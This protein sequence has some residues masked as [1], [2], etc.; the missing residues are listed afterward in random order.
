MTDH[1]VP[2]DAAVQPE[3]PPRR[4]QEVAVE[5]GLDPDTILPHGHFIAKVPFGLLKEQEQM[6]Q[7]DGHLILMTAM[8]PTPQGEGKTTTTI[9]LGDALRRM[10]EKTAIC[11]R[12]PSLGPYFGI[13]GGGTGAGRAQVTPAEAINL[14][15]TGDMYSVTKANNLLAAMVDNHIHHGNGL[16]I[17][18]RRIVLR[19]VMD[20]NDRALREIFVGLGGVKNGVPRKDGFNITPASEVMAILCLAD[21]YADLGRRLGDMVVGF[22]YKGEPVRATAIEAVG[23]MQV[24]L[25]DAIHPNLVQT[26][27]GTPAF[28]HGGPFA[29]IAQGT[30]TAMAT[31]MALKL[32][33]YVVTEAGFAT[34]LGAEKFFDIKC[35][36]AG[37][38][39]SA[40]VIVAT[41]K[42][43]VWHGGF[44][45]KGGLGNLL[46]HILNIRR[47]GLEPVVA[48][49]RFPQD[50]PADLR[51]IQR[52]CAGQNVE[53]IV[54]THFSEG[55][56]GAHDLAVAVRRA[57]QRNRRRRFRFLYPLT[58]SLEAKIG[59]VARNLYGADGVD[60]DRSAETD[61][62]LLTRHGF[63]RL[64]I[65]VAKTAL[66]LS[67]KP[68]LRGRP[69][70]F[71]ITVQELRL[72]AGAGFVVVICGNIV[73]MP[74]LPRVPAAARI[75]VLPD[76]RAIGLS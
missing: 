57:I 61:L 37:L 56:A 43:V 3:Q 67:D 5:L 19:R 76:G 29:N 41:V 17:D 73:T 10:G 71:R 72:A 59:Q 2:L 49:N 64:P 8:N 6:N 54:A 14:H 32:A 52:F 31:R 47:F 33:D 24:L 58:A 11:L 4:I 68:A 40:V 50:S 55:G 9:G 28:I 65:C 46:Q 35:R 7:P 48:I 22:T 23:A 18:P 74:G 20:L 25:R 21:G 38:K 45:P 12:E 13:K 53:A 36:V 51:R 69:A 66:S 27:E 70:G 15:F 63:D 60:Y 26:L 62:E 44:T 30:N 75:R 42:A 16:E 39:P 34:E 1:P